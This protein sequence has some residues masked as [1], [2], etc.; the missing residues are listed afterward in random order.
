MTNQLNNIIELAAQLVNEGKA[1]ID[2]AI[3]VAIR[4]DNERALKCIEDMADMSKGYVNQE[5]KTQKAF[6]ILLTSVY[7]KLSN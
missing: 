4:I 3:E 6:G 5:N 7:G 1:T 2:N